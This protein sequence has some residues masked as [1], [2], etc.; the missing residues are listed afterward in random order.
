MLDFSV[1]LDSYHGF[2]CTVLIATADSP[3]SMAA[4]QVALVDD[5]DDDDDD[6]P[7]PIWVTALDD[8]DEEAPPCI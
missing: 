1:G 4:V 3:F 2:T 6:D 8:E 7:N 5:E